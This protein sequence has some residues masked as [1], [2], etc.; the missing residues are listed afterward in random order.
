[1]KITGWRIVRRERAANAFT[2]EGAR[3]YGGR[4]NSPGVP[5]VYLSDSLALAALETL[6][7]LNPQLTPD[8]VCFRI[9]WPRSGMTSLAHP[10]PGW[11]TSPAGAASQRA[12]DAWAQ[13]GRSAVLSVPSIIVPGQR[14]YLLHPRHPDFARLITIHPPEPFAFDPRLTD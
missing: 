1:M 8:Y 9:E 3:L 6:V 11:N 10:A 13:S 4:W 14:N 12:G 2:G 7:H 5:L